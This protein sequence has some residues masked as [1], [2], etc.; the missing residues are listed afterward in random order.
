[1]C[2]PTSRV[3]VLTIEPGG[4][5]ETG[6]VWRVCRRAGTL[7]RPSK[8][9]RESRGTMYAVIR[10]GGKQ[11]RVEEG[12]KLEV[13]LVGDTDKI[14]LKPVLLVDDDEVLSTPGDLAGARV[15]AKV[16]GTTKGAKVTGF[17]YKNKTR[18]NRRWGHRQRYS[19]I[20]ITGIT[21]G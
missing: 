11:Y 21:K 19:L 13:E 5:G 16:L 9:P 17:T 1:M 2:L 4:A 10:T 20:E 14:E 6:P 15:K 7:A 3:R 12:Q 8:L 18:S